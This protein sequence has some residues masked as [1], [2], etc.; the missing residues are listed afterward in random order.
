[1]GATLWL[2]MAAVSLIGADDPKDAAKKEL[3]KFRGTWQFVSLEVE[4]MKVPEEQTKGA[5][6]MLDGDKFTYTAPEGNAKGTFKIDVTKKPKT[7]DITFTEGPNKGEK[8][9]GIYE[10]TT[11]TYKVC[12]GMP[13]KDRPQDFV[14]KQGSGHVLEVLKKTK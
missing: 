14:S 2:A 4:G 12:I 7:I 9:L 5:K 3:D 8:L 10:L 11:D 1:M 13:G 6:L